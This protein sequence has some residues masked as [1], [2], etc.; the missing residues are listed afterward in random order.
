MNEKEPVNLVIP[1]T[2]VSSNAY[3][4]SME[5]YQKEYQRSINEPEDFWSEVAEIF[6]GLKNGIKFA[7]LITT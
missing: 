3:F 1:S 4:S 6:I 7:L 5:E 2:S